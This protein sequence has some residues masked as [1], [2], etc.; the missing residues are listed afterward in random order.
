MSEI[1]S[2]KRAEIANLIHD[3]VVAVEGQG[4][5]YVNWIG[6]FDAG[7][8]QGFIVHNGVHFSFRALTPE[9]A[10]WFNLRTE[11]DDENG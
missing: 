1:T 11:M 8:L 10:E 5:P 2:I 4:N 3:T 7:E 9:M 6:V